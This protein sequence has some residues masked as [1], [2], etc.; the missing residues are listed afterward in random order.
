[1]TRTTKH[2]ASE[3]PELAFLNH[4]RR[5]DFEL[6]LRRYDLHRE[7]GLSYR[8]IALLES[9]QK[10]GSAVPRQRVVGNKVRGESEV[11]KSVG[12]IYEAINR[13]RY[14]A[15]R[16]RLDQPAAGFP[17]FSCP[18]HPGNNCTVDCEHWQAYWKRV[19]PTL[20]SDD[21]GILR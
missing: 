10:R 5:E 12:R 11:A 15:R 18:D 16:R 13:E 1:V 6:D 17:P 19:Q 8:L 20:P 7:H 2:K 4:V 9:Q 3:L 21:T 14:T